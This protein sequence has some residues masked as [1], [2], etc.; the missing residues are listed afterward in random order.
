MKKIYLILCISLLATK[1]MAIN[2]PEEYG[3]IIKGAVNRQEYCW[4]KRIQIGGMLL[5]GAMV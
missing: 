5:H 2:C 3:T 4:G 1:A